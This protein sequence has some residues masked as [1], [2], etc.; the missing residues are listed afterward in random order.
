MVKLYFNSIELKT[1]DS[2]SQA[3]SF[4]IAFLRYVNFKR[5]DITLLPS[6]GH[7]LYIFHNIEHILTNN[8]EYSLDSLCV[9]E[10]YN[11]V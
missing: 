2:L 1:F 3:E 7:M 8:Y 9:R 10:N 6:M 4:L 11:V 5:N